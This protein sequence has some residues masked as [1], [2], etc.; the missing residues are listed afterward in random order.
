M[1]SPDAGL[2][3][4]HDELVARLTA[5]ARPVRRLW[6]PSLRVASWLVLVGA[7]LAVAMQG[8]LRLDLAA[9][10][11]RPL[12]VLE[13]IALLSAGTLAASAALVAAVPGR[14]DARR[15][16]HYALAVAVLGTAILFCEPAS[17]GVPASSLGTDLRC[18]SCVALFGLLPL[19]AL[20]VA[21]RRAAP[22]DGRAAGAYAG[23]AAFL[24]G[25]TAVRVA[26]PIDDPIHLLGW[27]MLP[28]MLWATLATVLGAAW[29]MRWRRA[30]LGTAR[31]SRRSANGSRD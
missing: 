24:V 4:I 31:G 22:L 20:L 8:G 10:F 3:P 1:T 21:L 23:G 25:A 15:L 6:S 27:H 2:P 18:A 7:V 5:D 26:C 13:V 19:V 12:Y 14:G 9:Q 17:S 16:A 30:T 11:H 29:T 28:V